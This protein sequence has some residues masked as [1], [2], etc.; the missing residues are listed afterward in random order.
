VV[1]VAKFGILGCE[2]Q[3]SASPATKSE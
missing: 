1:M 2:A 3:R